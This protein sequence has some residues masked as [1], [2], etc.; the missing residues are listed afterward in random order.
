MASQ[1]STWS[2]ADGYLLVL[3]E[4]RGQPANLSAKR[5]ANMLRLIRHKLLDARHNL[6]EECVSLK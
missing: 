5:S 4:D 2:R 1:Q 6:A 3:S